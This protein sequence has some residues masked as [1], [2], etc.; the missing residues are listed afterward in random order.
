MNKMMRDRGLEAELESPKKI[1]YRN[2][3]CSCLSLHSKHDV[4]FLVKFEG[5]EPEE[6]YHFDVDD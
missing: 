5:V 6:Q 2:L 1:S 3:S 4:F